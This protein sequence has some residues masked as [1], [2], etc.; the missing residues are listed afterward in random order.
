MNFMKRF[1]SIGFQEYSLKRQKQI[2]VCCN[3]LFAFFVFC[4]IVFQIQLWYTMQIQMGIYEKMQEQCTKE[5]VHKLLEEVACFPVRK[6]MRGKATY[7]FDNGYG[8]DRTY[9]GKRKH[10]GIDIMT[11]NDIPGYFQVQSVCD[12]V[13][14]KIGWLELGGYRVGIRS[15]SGYYYYY[16]H[17]EKYVEGIQE[18]K[19]VSAGDVIG[20]MGNTGY[21]KEGTKGKFDV[22]LHFGIYKPVK[23]SE[24]TIN[25]YY[26][27][28]YISG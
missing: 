28:K 24:Q 6:D 3:V 14:E 5:E 11:S 21:G 22:H 7:F 17:L 10:E 12:G 1:F 13:V 9:G 8:A 26:I 20:Y 18:G 16:A 4:S 2:R 27:L 19:K 15:E 23:D 25:P